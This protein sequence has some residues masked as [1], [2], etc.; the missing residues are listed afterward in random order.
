MQQNTN[1]YGHESRERRPY[2]YGRQPYSYSSQRSFDSRST[3]DSRTMDS[4]P[5]EK[6]VVENNFPSLGSFP[7]LGKAA[8]AKVHPEKGHENQ[9]STGRFNSLEEIVDVDVSQS[10]SLKPAFS[11][12]SM[13][14]KAVEA[15]M[16]K[17]IEE[18]KVVL[19]SN[20][21]DTKGKK[22]Y[23]TQQQYLYDGHK[24]NA[25]D[26]VIVDDNGQELYFSDDDNDCN[27]SDNDNDD[28]DDGDN[29]W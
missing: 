25:D 29:A 28:N 10:G 7:A 9:G 5:L 4:R 13:A 18:K 16:K 24:Y 22:V 8:A 11:Y 26:V 1:T 21:I 27:D 12:S 2:G 6:P 19:K 15:P 23:M 14:S 20:K 3:M 17:I